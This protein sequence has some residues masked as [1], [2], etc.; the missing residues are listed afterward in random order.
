MDG[1]LVLLPGLYPSARRKNQNAT[2]IRGFPFW[3]RYNPW[4][5]VLAKRHLNPDIEYS[6]VGSAT[7]PTRK[8]LFSHRQLS[9]APG[10]YLENTSGQNDWLSPDEEK[11]R[12]F[13][14]RYA[15]IMARSRFVLCPAGAGPATFRLFE[16]MQMGRVPILISDDYVFPKGPPWKD[17]LLQVRESELDMLP[18]L[19]RSE[20]AEADDRGRLARRSWEEFFSEETF[21]HYLC[22]TLEELHRFRTQAAD[23]YRLDGRIVGE[24]WS[25][26][27]Y[28]ETCSAARSL[29]RNG[30]LRVLTALAKRPLLAVEPPRGSR[31]SGGA[32]PVLKE[33]LAGSG[34]HQA[35]G[36][37]RAV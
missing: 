10:L 20:R 1:P 32:S 24:F 36:E 28:R 9:V 8:R 29:L 37:P 7:S 12:S 31:V 25:R 18:D 14:L 35:E 17:F 33:S 5:E 2:R 19:V 26:A 30:A 15:E 23:L 21:F 13:F 27:A 22:E 16:T 3:R 34:E 4:I 11:K 6:F